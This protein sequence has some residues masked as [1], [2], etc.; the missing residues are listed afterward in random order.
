MKPR[1][2]S[3]NQFIQD[4]NTL[5][6]QLKTEIA[7]LEKIIESTP[8]NLY[9]K[10]REHFYLGCNQALANE[11]HLKNWRDIINTKLETYVDLDL[12]KQVNKIDEEIMTHGVEKEIEEIG[13]DGRT[14]LT[15]KTPLYSMNGQVDGL[16]GI[17]VDI[18]ARKTMEEDLRKAKE[19]AETANRIKTQFLENMRH[20]IRTPL[21]GIIGFSNLIRDE[22]K[23][24]RIKEY[25]EN[26]SVSSQTLMDL[27][28]EI[29]ESLRIASG[30]EPLLKQKFDLKAK[31]QHLIQLNQAKAGEKKLRLELD[32]DKKIPTYLVGDGKRIYRTI[33]ELVTNAL[34]FTPKGSVK[35][36]ATLATIDSDTDKAIIKIT[37][38]DTGIGIPAEQQAE[39]FTRF[40]RLTPSFQGVYKGIGMGL[41]IVKQFIDDLDAEIYVDSKPNNGSAFTC[42]IPLKKALT[43]DDLGVD[44]SLESAPIPTTSAQKSVKKN[45]NPLQLDNTETRIL[46][47]EDQPFAAHVVH[48]MLAKMACHV[49][50]APNGKS[51]LDFLEKNR[52]DLIFMDVGLPDISGCEVTKRVRLQERSTS[53]HIPIIALTAHVDVENRQSCIE[54]GMDAVL[55]KPL[56]KE[57]AQDILNAFVPKREQPQPVKAKSKRV[58]NTQAATPQSELLMLEGPVIDLALGVKVLGTNKTAVKQMIALMLKGAEQDD[59]P[60]MKIAHENQEWPTIREIAHKIRGGLVYCGTPRAYQAFSHLNDYVKAGNTELQEALYQQALTEMERVKK[61]FKP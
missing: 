22:V 47:V 41:T 32:Y 61:E 36:V 13:F 31:L 11:I 42:V 52:Y 10:N 6:H 60:K 57:R 46:L 26:L 1:L 8:W 40:H 19:A 27:M 9:W 16:L 28:N 23:D 37:V 38:T 21:A 35:V 17:S 3:N 4:E 7:R 30:E 24:E 43:D 15:R 25:A 44:R 34:K 29:L 55:S 18:T 58:K 33:L 12:A 48:D 56:S 14:F 49:D 5:V 45:S 54:A 51:A 20:D 2:K 50:V 39:I 59:I 53:Q